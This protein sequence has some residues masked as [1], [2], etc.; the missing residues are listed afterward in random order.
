MLKDIIDYI[1]NEITTGMLWSDKIGG[2]VQPMKLTQKQGDKT[3]I[4]IIPAYYNDA[5]GVCDKS[6]FKQFI[7]DSTF[8]SIIYWELNNDVQIVEETSRMNKYTASLRLVVWLNLKKIDSTIIN[9]DALADEILNLIPKSINQTMPLIFANI[10]AAS[11]L[12]GEKIFSKYTYNEAEQ[13]YLT[14][15]YS[16]FAFDFNIIFRTNS[17][18]TPTELNP[19]IC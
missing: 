4:K 19:A 3:I 8:K 15:P 16:A 13:Q 7:P 2:I 17:C 18:L 14:L 12:T 9:T 6:T 11:Y 1:N 10:K 5:Q